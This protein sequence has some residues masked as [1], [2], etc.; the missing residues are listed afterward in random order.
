MKKVKTRKSLTSKEIL[1]MIEK[2]GETLK[3]Y[4]VKRIGLFGSYVRG[5]QK[6]KSDIDMLVEFDRSAF[7]KNFTGYFDNYEGFSSFLKGLFG[8]NIDLLT[9][10]MIS[11][12]IK[13]FIL[14]E[15]KYLEAS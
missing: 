10:D 15:V 8:R 3:K 4:R 13:P 5:E 6:K 9:D 14:K 12:Y 1:T 7:D 11:P 2:Q